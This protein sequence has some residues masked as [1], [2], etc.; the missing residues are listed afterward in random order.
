MYMSLNVCVLEGALML[1]WLWVC[2]VYSRSLGN[3]CLDRAPYSS[4]YG[5][6]LEL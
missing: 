6:E 5:Q 3:A 4:F 1:E 2:H